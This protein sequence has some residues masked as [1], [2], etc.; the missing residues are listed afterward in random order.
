MKFVHHKNQIVSSGKK[1]AYK[2]TW[3]SGF[4]VMIAKVWASI[5]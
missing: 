2:L 3:I 4:D 1:K 5:L